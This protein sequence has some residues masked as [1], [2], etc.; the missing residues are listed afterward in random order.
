MPFDV[1]GHRPRTFPTSRQRLPFEPPPDRQRLSSGILYHQRR[2]RSTPSRG[3]RLVHKVLSDASSRSVARSAL[4]SG[5][6]ASR[7]TLFRE[8]RFRGR[9]KTS[10]GVVIPMIGLLC[11]LEYESVMDNI[12][13][14]GEM[15][16]HPGV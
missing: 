15:I 6:K 13:T 2:G 10:Y 12:F 7:C 4:R 16:L 14:T 3:E 5:T 9:G 8:V 11:H 1:D